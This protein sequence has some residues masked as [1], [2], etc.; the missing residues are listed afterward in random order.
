MSFFFNNKF[1]KPWHP[2]VFV[3]IIVIL[4][5]IFFG[6]WIY[7]KTG[8]CFDW[9]GFHTESIGVVLDVIFIGILWA[10][11]DHYRKLRIDL[12]RYKEEIIDFRNLKDSHITRKLEGNI[13]RLISKKIYDFD[14]SYCYLVDANLWGVKCTN[15]AFSTNFS[16][17][18]M[19]GS[20]LEGIDLS[21]SNFEGAHL[22]DSNLSG[23]RLFRTNFRGANLKDVDFSG[24][25]DIKKAYFWG[26][27][28]IEE[29]KFDKKIDLEELKLQKKEKY[30]L[31]FGEEFF[32]KISFIER[33]FNCSII[34]FEI[35][36]FNPEKI[37]IEFTK[38]Y[39]YNYKNLID[40]VGDHPAYYVGHI[41]L[42]NLI[43]EIENYNK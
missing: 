7:S 35:S 34:K 21:F 15:R 28:N 26:A 5:V 11:F 13:N 14:L 18:S 42:K 24:C 31:G 36:E 22:Y 32:K 8:E 12:K 9:I 4:A 3:L 1:V 25:I 10:I 6:V 27:L 20:K 19:A 33:K 30:E 41:N 17:A 38:E 39:F 16:K 43:D 2:Y 40:I 37:I 23:S 29:A